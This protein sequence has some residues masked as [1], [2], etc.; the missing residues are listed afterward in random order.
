[1]DAERARSKWLSWPVSP[2]PR[3]LGLEP[4]RSSAARLQPARPPR[5]PRT[6]RRRAAGLDRGSRT[7]VDLRNA[8]WSP[9]CMRAL[10]RAS[11]PAA[12]RGMIDHPGVACIVRGHRCNAD[13]RRSGLR[14]EHCH[15]DRLAA[16]SARTG[17]LAPRRGA[18]TDPGARA[19]G[20]ARSRRVAQ[21]HR[22]RGLPRPAAAAGQPARA[23]PL[24]GLRDNEDPG[25]LLR[26]F[27]ASRATEHAAICDF[28]LEFPATDLE[29]LARSHD[30]VLWIF[31]GLDEV[32]RSAGRDRVVAVIHAAAPHG[33]AHGVVVT[34]GLRDMKGSSAT[35][36]RSS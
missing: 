11:V 32:P 7:L 30:S 25:Q 15:N 16:P 5:R 22:Y 1:M 19:R 26:R 21:A 12:V 8:S 36:I 23:L 27:L 34:T 4:V 13:H 20:R 18:G 28:T 17:A 35:W 2:P 31:D 29:E 3:P 14:Q 10:R 33:A 24:D 6:T 9:V